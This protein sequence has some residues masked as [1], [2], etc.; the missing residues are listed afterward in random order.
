[1][2]WHGNG[3]LASVCC[4]CSAVQQ[5]MRSPMYVS[6]SGEAEAVD[7]NRG[8]NWQKDIDSRERERVPPGPVGRAHHTHT[9]ICRGTSVYALIF[10]CSHSL[11]HH[12]LFQRELHACLPRFACVKRQRQRGSRSYKGGHNKIICMNEWKMKN[13]LPMAVFF[14]FS[15]CFSTDEHN[16]CRYFDWRTNC[17]NATTIQIQHV[18]RYVWMQ[19]PFGHTRP[20]HIQITW[21]TNKYYLRNIARASGWRPREHTQ[22]THGQPLL[23]ARYAKY[24]PT[25]AEGRGPLKLPLTHRHSASTSH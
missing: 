20:C 22:H 3:E 12:S 25:E 17:I 10:P 11:F 7:T 5:H 23:R 14:C 9:L 19:L 21:L 2:Q 4:V 18:T 13:G 16:Y 6:V 15:F 8:H 24:A 1:M